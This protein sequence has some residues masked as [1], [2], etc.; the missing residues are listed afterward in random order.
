M[1]TKSKNLWSCS[2]FFFFS[3]DGYSHFQKG[4]FKYRNFSSFIQNA[5]HFCKLSMGDL[6]LQGTIRQF[7]TLG[8]WTSTKN[9]FLYTNCSYISQHQVLLLYV[10]RFSSP[11]ALQTQRLHCSLLTWQLCEWKY[12]VAHGLSLMLN[13]QQML[14][15]EAHYQIISHVHDQFGMNPL[16]LFWLKGCSHISVASCNR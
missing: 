4:L 12:V 1:Y 14:I 10:Y 16:S 5:D 2:V 8:Y 13:V 3:R 6:Q 15:V 7:L 11:V 9:T